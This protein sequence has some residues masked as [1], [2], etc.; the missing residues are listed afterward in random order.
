ML[1]GEHRAAALRWNPSPFQERQS[2]MSPILWT[3][4]LVLAAAA[5]AQA[6]LLGLQAWE[7]RRYVRSCMRT[8][9]QRLAKGRA[10]V[11]APCKGADVELEEN[12]PHCFARTTAITKLP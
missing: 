9:D 3:A 6:I 4:Y 5:V 11:L 7:Q 2:A 10:L 1:P 8:L 12:L